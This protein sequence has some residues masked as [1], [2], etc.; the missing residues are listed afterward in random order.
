MLEREGGREGKGGGKRKLWLQPKCSAFIENRLRSIFAIHARR[1]ILKSVI[2][3]RHSAASFLEVSRKRKKKKIDRVRLA[4]RGTKVVRESR[5]EHEDP[6]IESTSTARYALLA[7]V[8]EEELFKKDGVTL[9]WALLLFSA[10]ILRRFRSE[11]KSPKCRT[12]RESVN[13]A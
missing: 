7:R 2:S 9:E 8:P 5:E 10:C 12:S 11:K 1:A 6:I 13:F 3:I 4:V